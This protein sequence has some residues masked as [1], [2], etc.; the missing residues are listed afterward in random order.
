MEELLEIV[1][2][3]GLLQGYI[4]GTKTYQSEWQEWV[5]TTRVTPQSEGM[6]S[7]SQTPLLFEKEAPFKNTQKSGKYKNMVMGPNGV[8]KQEWLCWLGLAAIYWTRL[9]HSE[10]EVVVRQSPPGNRMGGRGT[11]SLKL[12]HSNA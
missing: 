10:S 4:L 9:D 5:N 8:Q 3:V 12:L 11:Q 1:F 6:T 7:S 2:T